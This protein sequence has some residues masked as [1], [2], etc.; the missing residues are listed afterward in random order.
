MINLE[1]SI[2]ILRTAGILNIIESFDSAKNQLEN[3]HSEDSLL[4]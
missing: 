4:K 2:P 3:D 1:T